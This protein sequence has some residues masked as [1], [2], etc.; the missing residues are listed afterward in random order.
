MATLG[1]R[2]MQASTKARSSPSTS[3]TLESSITLR[4]LEPGD[5]GVTSRVAASPARP[6]SGRSRVPVRAVSRQVTRRCLEH[7]GVEPSVGG[8]G[9]HEIGPDQASRD[10]GALCLEDALGI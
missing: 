7:P 9:L 2:L 8:L 3:N 1:R 5:A 10:A 6:R 4:G